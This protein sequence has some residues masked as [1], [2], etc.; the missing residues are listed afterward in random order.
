MLNVTLLGNKSDTMVMDFFQEA[1]KSK[2]GNTIKD[3]HE[4][5]KGIK[6]WSFDIF[7]IRKEDLPKVDK[8][9]LITQ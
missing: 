9:L 1:K 6:S 5:L 7:D 4:T 3:I 2:D 8:L